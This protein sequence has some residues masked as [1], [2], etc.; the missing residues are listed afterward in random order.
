[1]EWTIENSK[2]I[3]GIGKKDL[4]YLDINSEGQLELLIGDG[5][6]TFKEILKKVQKNT[7]YSSA[8]FALRIPQLI[9]KQIRKLLKSFEDAKSEFQYKGAYEPIYPIKVS[10]TKWVIETIIKSHPTYGF[11]SGTKSEFVLLEHALKDEKHRLIMCN[12]VKDVKY[13]KEIRKAIK[14]G[15]KVCISIES[16]K[17]MKSVVKLLP[18]E[19]Y[20]LAL[21]IKPYTKLHGHWGASS[22]RHSKFGLS[23]S[24][25]VEVVNVIKDRG[26][27]QLVTTLHSHPGSQLTNL[28]DIA[29]FVSFI[30][31]IYKNLLEQG[32]SELKALDFGG[33]LAIDYDNRLDANFMRKYADVI[34]GEVAKK[35]SDVHPKIMTESGR[36]ITASFAMIMVNIIDKFTTF[37]DKAPSQELMEKFS[38]KIENYSNPKTVE[39]ALKKWDEWN[40]QSIL[41]LDTQTLFAFE[42]ISYKLKKHLREKFFN[43]DNYLEYLEH[44]LTPSLLKS[45]HS[46]LGNFS[47]FNSICDYVLVNQYFPI[48]PISDL[49]TQPETLVRLLD[50]TCDS[51]GEFA[52]YHPAIS[53]QKL[54]TKDNF[55][56]TYQEPI[57]IN[58]LPISRFD[59]IVDKYLLIPLVGAYQDIIEFD[60]NLL[61]DL[62]DIVVVY[63]GNKWYIHLANGAQSI[64]SLLADIGYII[65]NED[66]P[67]VDHEE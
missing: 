31:N 56:I 62:P 54:F 58:G 19:G 25:L 51:D 26:L 8:S 5:R 36:A 23:I 20:Q 32:L 45:E 15:Y 39:D 57:V 16:L 37:P 44:P 4:S 18:K 55:L 3:Y 49:H 17:E 52:T 41:D 35:L 9:T 6:I 46:I 63:D 61:G 67:Y 11:E 48:F 21:R 38:K 13:L 29:N 1:M 2:L 59:I 53:D 12:G 50:I 22:G 65:E 43:F 64:S 33:G 34:V 60:H 42:Y 14:K 24:E 10:S 30:S 66:D 28:D 7:K 27:T 40:D 47:V